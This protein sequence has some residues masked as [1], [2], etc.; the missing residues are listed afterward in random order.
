MPDL[1]RSS[2]MSWQRS[3]TDLVYA[4]TD[5]R[6]H[7]LILAGIAFAAALLGTMAI[8]AYGAGHALGLVWFYALAA[9]TLYCLVRAFMEWRAGAED[10]LEAAS[11]DGDDEAPSK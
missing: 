1:V 2:S 4:I 6:H 3:L 8:L 7:W 10:A 9:L 11:R 5:S